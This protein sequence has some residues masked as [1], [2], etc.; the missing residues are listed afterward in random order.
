[1]L[2][3]VVPTRRPVAEELADDG[4]IALYDTAGATLIVLNPSAAAI[5]RLL[6]GSRSVAEVIAVL[7]EQFDEDVAVIQSDVAETCTK[8]EE[9]GLVE[10]RRG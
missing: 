1:M 10:L 5:W 8:L 2:P 3:E 4:K 9:L 7:V 6:D